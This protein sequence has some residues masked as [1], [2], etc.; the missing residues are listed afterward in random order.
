MFLQTFLE[1]V[2]FEQFTV[3]HFFMCVSWVYLKED[4]RYE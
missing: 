4:E 3:I 2:W 1:A